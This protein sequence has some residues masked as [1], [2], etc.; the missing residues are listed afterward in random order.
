MISAPLKQC[1]SMEGE[2]AHLVSHDLHD[3]HPAV[4]CSGGVDAVDGG[5]GN[6]HGALEAEGHVGAP[7]IVVDGLRAG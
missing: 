7:D 1:L 4:G 3:E 2:P 6:V 5:G